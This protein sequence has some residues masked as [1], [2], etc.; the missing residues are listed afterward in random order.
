MEVGGER[1]RIEI[2]IK[3]ENKEEEKRRIEFRKR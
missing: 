2:E 3:E 1:E